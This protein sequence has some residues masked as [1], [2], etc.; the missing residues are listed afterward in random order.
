MVK[1]HGSFE[2]ANSQRDKSFN[3]ILEYADSGD[4][5]TMFQEQEPPRA[6]QDIM[7]FWVNLMQVLSALQHIHTVRTQT[8]MDRLLSG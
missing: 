8:G 7:K 1:Y 2:S 3:I 5:E 4:L 6:S